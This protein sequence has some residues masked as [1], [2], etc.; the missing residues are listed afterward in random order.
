MLR[1]W[2]H[3]TDVNAF[4]GTKYF[5]TLHPKQQSEFNTSVTERLIINQTKITQHINIPQYPLIMCAYRLSIFFRTIPNTEHR[6]QTSG[7]IQIASGIAKI[8]L[9][10]KLDVTSYADFRVS[11]WGTVGYTTRLAATA[12][13]INKWWTEQ[14]TRRVRESYAISTTNALIR[15]WT[16]D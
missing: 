12:Q 4:N 9:A 1:V 14:E 11:S 5:R 7:E 10:R 15:N 13:R 2:V 8:F 3:S 16:L 6:F